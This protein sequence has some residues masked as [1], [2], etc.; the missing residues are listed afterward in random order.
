M[1]KE[2]SQTYWGCKDEARVIEVIQA[3]T[4]LGI[5][6]RIERRHD[7]LEWHGVIYSTP[8]KFRV[9]MV[10]ARIVHTVGVEE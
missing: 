9:H 6:S 4:E 5:D 2:H 8:P 10:D 1:E 3:L 7:P